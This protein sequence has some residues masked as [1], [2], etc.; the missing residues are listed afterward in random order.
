MGANG[1]RI[2]DIVA[3]SGRDSSALI[4]VLQDVQAEYNYLSEEAIQVI[5]DELKMPVSSVYGVATFFKAFTFKPRGKHLATVCLGT[6]CHVRG[7]GQVMDELRTRLGVEPGETTPDGQFTLEAVNCLGACALGPI[8]VIDGQ[9]HGQM[10]AQ[11]TAQLLK[12][13]GK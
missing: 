9:Y 6:A 12:R 2:K 4:S 7:A 11:K 1:Q 10:T 8:V 5:S 3:K 13:Y